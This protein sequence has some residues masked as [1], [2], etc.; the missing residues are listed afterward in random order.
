MIGLDV[1]LEVVLEA[2][3]AQEAY[4]S[5]SVVIVLV[6]G[7]LSGLRLDE[8]LRGAPDLVAVVAAHPKE[9][10]HVV[11]L[12]LDVG[13]EDALVA[14][15]TSP[16]DD[17]LASELVVDLD[18]LLGLGAGVSEG[19]GVGVGGASVHVTRVREEVLRS[20][21]ELDAGLLLL[22]SEVVDDLVEHLVGLLKGR[23]LGGDVAVMEGVVA[24]IELHEHLK[25]GV[26]AALCVLHAVGLIVKV[27]LHGGGSKGISPLTA[28]GVPVA[29]RESAPLLHCLAHYNLR[30]IVES[31]AQ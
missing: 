18:D 15:A 22:L 13:V 24:D 3:S 30:L 8:E 23:A 28:E 29:Q 6:L 12:P 19:G 26:D 1:N 21:E 2:V 27:P 25:H 10:G 11:H 7:G 31:V 20:P 14:L 9:R 4:D 17:V 5:L 16:V